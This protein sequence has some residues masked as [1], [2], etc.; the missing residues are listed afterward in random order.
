MTLIITVFMCIYLYHSSK[1]NINLEIVTFLVTT[2]QADVN[3]K[4]KDGETPLHN[5]FT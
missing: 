5:A 3:S 4:D 2:G 1:N